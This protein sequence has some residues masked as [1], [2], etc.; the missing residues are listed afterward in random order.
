VAAL[1]IDLE[2]YRECNVRREAGDAVQTVENRVFK[3]KSVKLRYVET[4]E[5][6]CSAP[7]VINSL[8]VSY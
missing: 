4:K 3:D 2:E 1:P 5:T 6:I 7:F 8:H